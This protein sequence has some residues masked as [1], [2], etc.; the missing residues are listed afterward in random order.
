MSVRRLLSC[1]EKSI[2]S[3]ES[4]RERGNEGGGVRD[5]ERE[6]EI[7]MPSRAL[8]NYF[9]FVYAS[10]RSWSQQICC[11]CVGTVYGVP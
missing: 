5:G 6:R 2:Q 10:A 4:A 1:F 7:I 9:C 11:S 8:C 3:T